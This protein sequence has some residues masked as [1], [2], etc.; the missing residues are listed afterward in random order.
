[1]KP[2]PTPDNTIVNLRK[3]GGRLELKRTVHGDDAFWVL[4][5]AMIIQRLVTDL[6]YARREAVSYRTERDDARRDCCR[7]EADTYDTATPESIASKRGWDC[8]TREVS[9]AT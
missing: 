7:C 9:D 1:M 2:I 3:I 4:S 8:Y 6:E 5:A